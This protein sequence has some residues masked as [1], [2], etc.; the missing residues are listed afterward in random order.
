MAQKHNF[1]WREVYAEL[2]ELS[3][4]DGF[5]E[6]MDTMVREIVYD[7]LNFKDDFYV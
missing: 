4:R 5:E 1:T 6:A 3:K 7:T 2:Q